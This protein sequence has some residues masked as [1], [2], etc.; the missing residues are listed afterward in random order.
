ME[1]QKPEKIPFI[2]LVWLIVLVIPYAYTQFCVTY[3]DA[4]GWDYAAYIHAAGY[5]LQGES[6]Y[7]EALYLYPPP[8]A[9][10]MIPFCYVSREMGFAIWT[11]ISLMAYGYAVMRTVQCGFKA[12]QSP[13]Q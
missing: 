12:N 11:V 5:I 1:H 6:P 8:L 2:M 10:I 4:Y 9:V 7:N 3:D 13:L